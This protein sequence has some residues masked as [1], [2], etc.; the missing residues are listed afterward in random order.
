MAS[1]QPVNPTQVRYIKLGAGGTWARESIERGIARFDFE[2]ASAERFP[3]CR[4][5]RWDELYA[6]F[7]G[8]QKT[9]GASRNFTNQTQQ[10][11][12]DDGSTL[13]ITFHGDSLYWGKFGE[14][15]AERHEDG[16]GVWRAILGG[17]RSTDINGIPLLTK[18][19]PGKLTKL[20]SFRGTSCAVD[21]ADYIISRIN[22][23]QRDEIKNALAA[24]ERMEDAILPLVRLLDPKDFELLV[25]LIFTSSGWRRESDVGKTAKT[26][27]MIIRLP[28]TD[29][30]AG[31]QVKSRTTPRELA[32]YVDQFGDFSEFQRLFYVYHSGEAATD[33]SRITV[34]GPT[35]LVK[36]VLDAGLTGWLIDHVI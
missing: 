21:A 24:R 23:Q 13:W 1:L 16:D 12:E 31:V 9:K 7:L 14:A 22:C 27:D 6:S 10:F 2:S 11:F 30:L 18:G 32:E 25:D 28:T 35:R 34:I 29:S 26:L 33:D 3:L 19:L 8:E 36:L 4:D 17:W 15:R 5:G 20:A